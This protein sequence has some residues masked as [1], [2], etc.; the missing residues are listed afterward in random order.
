MLD[1]ASISFF[2]AHPAVDLVQSA[3]T[4]TEN[5]A[6]PVQLPRHLDAA[7]AVFATRTPNVINFR[8]LRQ[9]ANASLVSQALEL[10]LMVAVH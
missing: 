3:T 2:R 10:G 8:T 4:A 5:L 1:Q 9:F 6:N 7:I